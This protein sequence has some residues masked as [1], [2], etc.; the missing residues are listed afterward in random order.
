MTAERLVHQGFGKDQV[1][2]ATNTLGTEEAIVARDAIDPL[3]QAAFERQHDLHDRPTF[4]LISRAAPERRADLLLEAAATL[5]D[6]G[7]SPR[8]VFIGSGWPEQLAT[9]IARLKLADV[10]K[11]PGSLYGE[12][13]LAPWFAA[14][15]AVVLP[16][17]A[18]L[19]VVHAMAHSKPVVTHYDM[20]VHAPEARVIVHEENGLLF[21]RGDAVS[22]AAALRRL[23]EEPGLRHRLG[24][25]AARAATKKLTIA[26]MV[27]GFIAAIEHAA[28][29]GR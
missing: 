13:A 17:E 2:V 26:N 20:L 8:L 5:R 23:I 12:P 10:V 14:S 1:Y 24:D 19:A 22:L 21:R 3:E 29:A 7:M 16:A 28:A 4:L 15:T 27:D 18:G 9:D 11:M 6:E 25:N